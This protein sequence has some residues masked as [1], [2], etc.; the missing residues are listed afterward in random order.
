MSAVLTETRSAEMCACVFFSLTIDL[1]AVLQISV[2]QTD[3]TL[4][5][6]GERQRS[7]DKASEAQDESQPRYRKQL[8]RSMGKFSRT[9][10]LDKAADLSAVSAR[11]IVASVSLHL[12]FRPKYDLQAQSRSNLC[13]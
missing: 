10:V 3:R 13:K 7:S 2:N 6:A 5:V 8:E 11:L 1:A 4:K 12:C 9:V